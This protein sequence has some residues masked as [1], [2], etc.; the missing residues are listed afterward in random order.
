MPIHPGDR[1]DCWTSRKRT[2]ERVEKHI[3]KI[4][5]TSERYPGRHETAAR[6][7]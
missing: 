3:E 7:S 1:S 2:V 6:Q 5:D 4:G